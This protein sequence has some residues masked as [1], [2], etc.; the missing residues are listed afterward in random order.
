MSQS[1]SVTSTPPTL[2][3]PAVGC[4]SRLTQRSRVDLPEPD[5][6]MTQTTSP[7]RI[8]DVDALE[9]LVR[10]EGLVQAR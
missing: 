2:T 6:P 5:G 7:R 1:G 10:P 9:H 8:V 3:V 4:S